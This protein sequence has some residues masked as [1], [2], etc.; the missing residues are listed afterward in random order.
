[1]RRPVL[2][3]PRQVFFTH[4]S[5]LVKQLSPAPHRARR[6]SNILRT[7]CQWHKKIP[8]KSSNC[9]NPR[10]SRNLWPK[11][12]FP[13]AHTPRATPVRSLAG[14]SLLQSKACFDIVG[15]FVDGPKTSRKRERP[16]QTNPKYNKRRE[17]QEPWCHALTLFQRASDN[18]V[19]LA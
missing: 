17:R 10:P 16:E 14:L 12:L 9:G 3:L 19:I 15:A 13:A 6:S 11:N 18:W 1:M 5:S 7:Q 2:G 8:T 4:A